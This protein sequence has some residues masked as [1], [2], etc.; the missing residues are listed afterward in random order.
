[1]PRYVSPECGTVSGGKVFFV[2][3]GKFKILQP[4]ISDYEGQSA[5]RAPLKLK[6]LVNL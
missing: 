4:F 6:R 2:P 1:M 3:S 5:C